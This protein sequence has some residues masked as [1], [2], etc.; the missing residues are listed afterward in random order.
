MAE[1]RRVSRRERRELDDLV[2]LLLLLM[3]LLEGVGVGLRSLDWSSRS[4][5]VWVVGVLT[6]EGEEE[7]RRGGN[8]SDASK[9]A[10]VCT[11]NGQLGTKG[12]TRDQ[13]PVERHPFHHS[14]SLDFSHL[15]H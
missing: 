9:R 10:H 1:S 5:T 3:L 8:V 2:L 11:S 13:K 4:S 14:R 6:W 15:R 12:L 7:G